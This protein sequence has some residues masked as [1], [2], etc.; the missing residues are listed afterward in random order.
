MPPVSGWKARVKEAWLVIDA[1]AYSI[2]CG[3]SHHCLDIKLLT[4]YAFKL[5][6]LAGLHEPA[7]R[8]QT[9]IFCCGHADFQSLACLILQAPLELEKSQADQ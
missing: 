6:S 9:Q 7:N 8:F 4:I 2:S 5:N 3:I 1:A